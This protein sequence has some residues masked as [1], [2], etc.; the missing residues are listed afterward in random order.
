MAGPAST[1]RSSARMGLILMAGQIDVRL[2]ADEVARLWPHEA[3]AAA[4]PI[5]R[6][7]RGP[8][9]QLRNSVKA[10]MGK[11][12]LNVLKAMKVSEMEK[13]FGASRHTCRDA[14][15]AHLFEMS[16]LSELKPWPTRNKDSLK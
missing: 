16:E 14:R 8:K 6:R 15:K 13:R 2:S 7:P 9:T 12:P 11:Y 4:V 10:A 1:G 5:K 3:A